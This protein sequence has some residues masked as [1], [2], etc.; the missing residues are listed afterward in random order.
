MHEYN[1]HLWTSVG[2]NGEKDGTK[3]YV[4]FEQEMDLKIEKGFDI[5]PYQ[6]DIGAFFARFE[7]NGTQ[8]A[9]NI[10]LRILKGQLNRRKIIMASLNYDTLLDRAMLRELGRFC[11]LEEGNGALLNKPHGSCNFLVDHVNL[12]TGQFSLMVNGDAHGKLDFP[13]RFSLDDSEKLV[14]EIK[15]DAI[16]PIMRIYASKKLGP[17]GSGFLDKLQSEFKENVE[18]ASKIIVIGVRVNHLD[19]HIWGELSKSSA[20]IYLVN[21]DSQSKEFLK[22]R[23]GNLENMLDGYFQ[24]DN[25]SIIRK[26]VQISKT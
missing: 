3:D 13:P 16:P 12:K 1:P 26:M 6:R 4:P 20:E 11:Y 14:N 10:L 19:K 15:G 23:Y 8:N 18:S 22:S 21:K 17:I 2:Y 25:M 7:S 24:P 9:Y 5:V